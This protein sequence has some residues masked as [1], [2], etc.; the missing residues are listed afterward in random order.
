MT[1][2]CASQNNRY[3]AKYP[4]TD[5]RLC[6]RQ[7]SCWDTILDMAAKLWEKTEFGYLGIDVVLDKEKG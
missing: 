5:A 1:I 3:I 2:F 4:D 7:I 6:D